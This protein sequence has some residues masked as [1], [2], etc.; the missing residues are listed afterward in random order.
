MWWWCFGAELIDNPFYFI[1][2]QSKYVAQCMEEC[3]KELKTDNM[4]LKTQ[5]ISKLTYVCR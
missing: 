4:D 2:P 3:R 5:A 1:C